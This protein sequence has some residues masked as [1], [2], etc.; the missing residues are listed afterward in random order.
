MGKYSMRFAQFL[1]VQENKPKKIGIETKDNWVTVGK[2]R[3]CSFKSDSGSEY[4]TQF[5]DKVLLTV[6]IRIKY[7]PTINEKM[8]V[9]LL[10][11]SGEEA[12]KILA[13]M[14]TVVNGRKITQLK[15]QRWAAL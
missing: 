8:R 9:V 2:T 11:K 3:K 13:V 5:A 10:S 12:F 1:N 7:D 6:T 14:P 15:I 4:N